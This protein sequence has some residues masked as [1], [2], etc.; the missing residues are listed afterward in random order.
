MYLLAVR[1]ILAQMDGGFTDFSRIKGDVVVEGSD[2]HDS[3]NSGYRKVKILLVVAMSL[4]LEVPSSRLDIMSDTMVQLSECLSVIC[5]I[6]WQDL[7][8]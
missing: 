5:P 8:G 3:K 2:G 1:L 6:S 7:D 4:S